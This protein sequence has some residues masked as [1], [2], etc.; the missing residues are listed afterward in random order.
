MQI[1]QQTWVLVADGTKYLLLH[2]AG[3]REAL[4]LQIVAHETQ[5]NPPARDLGSDRPGR[6]NDAARQTGNGVLTWGKSALEQT[7]W[8]RVGEARFAAHVAAVLADHAAAGRFR[9]LVILADPRT[10]GALRKA[11][12]PALAAMILAEIAKDY[13]QHPRD[14]IE[15]AITALPPP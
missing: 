12:D 1:E 13:T 11:F 5:P 14:R 4:N 8:H 6:R 2:N 15:A 9:H 10:L 3:D 7:D